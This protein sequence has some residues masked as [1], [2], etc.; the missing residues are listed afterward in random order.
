MKKEDSIISFNTGDE[1]GVVMELKVNGDVFW[2]KEGKLTLAKVDKDLSRA[3]Q[4]VLCELGEGLSAD[5]I[6]EN[7]KNEAVEEYLASQSK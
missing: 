3:F 2:M 5:K 4:L 1:R 7:I 6:I